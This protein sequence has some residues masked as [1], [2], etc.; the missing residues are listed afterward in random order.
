MQYQVSFPVEP[1][2]ENIKLPASKSITN[3]VLIIRALSLNYFPVYNISD[4]DDSKVLETALFNLE[5]IEY[6]IGHAGTAMRFLTALFA[7]L[8]GERVLSGSERMQ[9]RPVAPLVNALREL[10]ADISYQK[11]E[12]YPPLLIRGKKLEGREIAIPANMSS[13][14]I[15]AL[16]LIAPTLPEGIRISL[17]G[18]VLSRPYLK[19]TAELMRLAGVRVNFVD[20][21]IEVFPGKYHF[22]TFTVESDWSAASYWFAFAGMSPRSQ[23][24]LQGLHENSLQGDAALVNIF[25]DIG[26]KTVFT[27]E[28]LQLKHTLTDKESFDYDFCDQPDLAQTLAVYLALKNIPFHLKGLYNLSIKETDRIEALVNEL[29][30]LGYAI[31]QT[32]NEELFWDG[33]K[34]PSNSKTILTYKDHRMAMA[35]AVAASMF[36]EIEINEP[37]VVTKS[38]PGFWADLKKVGFGIAKVN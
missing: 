31:K 18:R 37:E 6:N 29:G 1:I 24:V 20:T 13:Q 2:V 9:Q 38:Y 23:F 8:P 36:A 35:F 19:M 30:K 25:E 21:T 3:R 4:S 12:G 14:F 11:E 34:T 33:T 10:G 22:D 15:S 32:N 17:Q 27:Q 28:G 16:M 26:V 7:V 5:E